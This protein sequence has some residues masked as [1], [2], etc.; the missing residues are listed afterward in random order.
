[1][2]NFACT[3]ME[4][5]TD[6]TPQLNIEHRRVTLKPDN[7]FLKVLVYEFLFCQSHE[8]HFS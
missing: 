7:V 2:N 1:M 3:L 8:Q 5:E 6:A 4:V